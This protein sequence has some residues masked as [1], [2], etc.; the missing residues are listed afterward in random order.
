M[1]KILFF[2]NSLI[3][4]GA[5]KVLVDLVNYLSE[6][7]GYE[8]ELISIF[9]GVHE[10]RLSKRVK[11]KKIIKT[12]RRVL[13][14]IFM[15]A[16]CCMPKGVFREVFI[17]GNYDI[18][19][20]YLE[21]FPTKVIATGNTNSKKIA[22]VHCDVST[23]DFVK[24]VYKN[25]N[26]C[27]DEY[28]KFESVCFVSEVAKKGFEKRVGR[29]DNF[30]V[31]HNIINVDEIRDKAQKSEREVFETKGLKIITVGSLSKEK[32]FDRLVRIAS[33]LENKY[34]FEICIVGEGLQR[35]I[36]ENLIKELNVK[37][38]KLTGF[39]DNPYA[40][41]NQADIFICPSYSEGYSTVVTE[42]LILGLPVLTTDCAG[43]EELIG[44]DGCGII[45]EN[46]EQG[47]LDG[48]ENVLRNPQV[49]KGLKE[50]AVEKSK[51]FSLEKSVLEY[52]AIL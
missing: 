11:Y 42:S 41:M 48:L 30:K 26:D 7:P 49:I 1:K 51:G 2:I 44:N 10:K 15:K 35:R 23:V 50:R 45:T 27:L 46:S 25:N 16:F 34:D 12:E 8:I 20:A 37:S 33:V 17:K 28:S 52:K 39:S 29:L 6:N 9:G 32:G 14:K 47:L 38:I 19:V 43:M 18:E 3:G 4:R 24:A 5:E 36:V 40:Y 31:V 21:G 13:K 22:F